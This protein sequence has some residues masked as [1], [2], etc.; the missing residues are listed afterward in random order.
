MCHD[1]A[2]K[3]AWGIYD[4]H[5]QLSP[6]G[7]V[8]ALAG[9]FFIEMARTG[10]IKE[11]PTGDVRAMMAMPERK[12]GDLT[13]LLGEAATEAAVKRQEAV[14]AAQHTQA[15]QN[16]QDRQAAEQQQENDTGKKW[17]DGLEDDD[18]PF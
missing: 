4:R 8:G 11:L 9:S 15:V 18:I 1:A 3:V 5:G 7:G 12:L 6:G 2:V 14:A 10:R 16:K 17:Q 13:A